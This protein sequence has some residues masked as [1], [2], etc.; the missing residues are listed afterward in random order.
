MKEC[1]GCQNIFVVW[2]DHF[3]KVIF[4]LRPENRKSEANDWK[5]SVGYRKSQ[6]KKVLVVGTRLMC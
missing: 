2:K 3:E 6:L 5:K 1:I 4:Q